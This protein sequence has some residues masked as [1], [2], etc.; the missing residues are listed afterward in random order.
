M[1]FPYQGTV[2]SPMLSFYNFPSALSIH[3]KN[4]SLFCLYLLVDGFIAF[5]A[6]IT[7]RT[8]L[9]GIQKLNLL[10]KVFS[11]CVINRNLKRVFY[12]YI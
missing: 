1:V 12:M 5:V 6:E 4:G 8:D 11:L 7:H 10:Q 9:T 3:L 2:H